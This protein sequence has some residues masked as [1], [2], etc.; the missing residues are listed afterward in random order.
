MRAAIV[1]YVSDRFECE[2]KGGRNKLKGGLGGEKTPKALPIIIF[3]AVVPDLSGERFGSTAE[4]VATGVVLFGCCGGAGVVAFRGKAT[5]GNTS[6][7][8]PP[9]RDGGTDSSAEWGLISLPPVGGRASSCLAS[10]PTT[11]PVPRNMAPARRRP[12][13]RRKREDRRRK[14]RSPSPPPDQQTSVPKISRLDQISNVKSQISSPLHAHQPLCLK[15][16]PYIKRQIS[17]IKSQ[18]SK[19]LYL[20]LHYKKQ[21]PR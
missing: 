20:S 4:A 16:P 7:T 19:R 3:G 15:S 17:N 2:S 10:G 8:R 21:L 13:F 6:G 5:P 18:I 12:N 14:Q 9:R 1:I 11:L